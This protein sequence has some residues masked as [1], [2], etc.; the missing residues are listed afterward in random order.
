MRF[1]ELSDRIMEELGYVLRQVDEE[2][3]EKLTASI[4]SSTEI[5]IAGMGRSG[6]MARPFA[7]RLMQMGFPVHLAGD[8]TTP[9]IGYGDLLIAIGRIF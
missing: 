1:S 9:A 3:V 8:A 5:F 2:D 7:M 4:L 6:L